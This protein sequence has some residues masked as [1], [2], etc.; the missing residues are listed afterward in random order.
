MVAATK[1]N[2]PKAGRRGMEGQGNL[3]LFQPP[4][5]LP[6]SPP[7]PPF[8]G[9]CAAVRNKRAKRRPVNRA[10][11]GGGIYGRKRL[12]SK[13]ALICLTKM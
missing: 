10:P 4:C 8:D 13:N 3:R 11:A 1:G 5:L 2:D 9:G 7:A 6:S 12:S